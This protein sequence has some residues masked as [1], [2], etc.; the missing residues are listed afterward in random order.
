MP[1][2]RN[3]LGT[4][5]SPASVNFGNCLYHFPGGSSGF[6]LNQFCNASKSSTEIRPSQERSTRCFMKKGGGFL[7]FGILVLSMEHNPLKFFGQATEFV[8]VLGILDAL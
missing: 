5:P 8:F 4:S 3:V 6:V 7:I 1:G 2:V